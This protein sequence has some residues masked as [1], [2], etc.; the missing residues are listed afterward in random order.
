[1]KEQIHSGALTCNSGMNGILNLGLYNPERG[2]KPVSTAL[3][4]KWIN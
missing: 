2:Q 4:N 1:M 3:E